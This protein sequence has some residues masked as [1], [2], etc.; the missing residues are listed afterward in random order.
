MDVQLAANYLCKRYIHERFCY[1]PDEWPPFQP[2]HFT[3]LVLI[4]HKENQTVNATQELV[5]TGN[6][7]S[8]LKCNLFSSQWYQSRS[9][10]ELFESFHTSRSFLIEGAPG[11]GKTVLLKEIA[12]QWATGKLPQLKELVFLIYLCDPNLKTMHSVEQLM[13]YIFKSNQIAVDISQYLFQTKGEYLTIIFDGYDEFPEE[14][15][16]NSL[17]ANIIN[18]SVLPECGL[19]ITSRPNASLHLRD[20]ADC[21]VEVLGFTE[22]DRLDYIQHALEGSDDKIRAVQLYLRSHY[23]I[24]ALCYIPLNMTILLSLFKN[25]NSS[26]GDEETCTLP[27]TQTEMYG[28]FITL[29][30]V[31]FLRKC[32]IQCSVPL[33][34]SSTLPSPYSKMFT[35][36]SQLAFTGLQNDKI[37]FDMDDIIAICPNL[38]MTPEN[39][40]GLG[41]LKAITFENKVSFHFLHFSIQEY[42]AANYIALLSNKKQIQLLKS[43]FWNISYFNTWIMY[44]GITGGKLLA[45]KHFL[46][47]NYF[48]LSSRLLK[49]SLSKHLQSDK[50]KSLHLFQCFL[51]AAGDNKLVENFS[52]D[53]MCVIDLSSQ[54]L[55]VTDVNTLAY[56]LLRSS[57]KH[58]KVLN[59]SKCHISDTGCDILFQKLKEDTLCIEKVDLSYNYLQE[60]SIL[61]SLH[62]FKTWHTSEAI[63]NETSG[64]SNHDDNVYS[65]NIY[66][67]AFSQF[68]DKSFSLVVSINYFLFAYKS[69]HKSLYNLLLNLPHIHSLYFDKCEWQLEHQT[70]EQLQN[71]SNLMQTRVIRELHMIDN[72]FPKHTFYNFFVKAIK[73]L[74][75]VFICERILP[76]YDIDYIGNTLEHSAITWILVGRSKIVGSIHTFTALKKMLSASE[77]LILLKSIRDICSNSNVPIAFHYGEIQQTFCGPLVI[78]LLHKVASKHMINICACHAENSCLIAN[79]ISYQDVFSALFI[80]KNLVSIFISNCNLNED[81]YEAA[82]D[83]F[84]K[85]TSLAILYLYDSFL[86]THFI[87]TI[88]DKLKW[89]SLQEF[90]VHSTDPLCT[91]NPDVLQISYSGTALMLVTRSMVTSI[92]PSERQILLSLQLEPNVAMWK[93]LK[94]QMSVV[95]LYQIIDVLTNTV[96]NVTSIDIS[97]CNLGECEYEAFISCVESRSCE[98]NWTKLNLCWNI[99]TGKLSHKVASLLSHITKL[100]ELN[101]SHNTLQTVSAIRIFRGMKNIHNLRKFNISYNW[102]GD[103]AAND[104]VAI[105]LSNT[106]L[107]ELDLSCN[108]FQYKSVARILS[109]NISNLI[110]INISH[111]NVTN[112]AAK[113]IAAF[114]TV[115][116]KLKKIKLNNIKLH[117]TGAIELFK[118]INI[119]ALTKLSFSHNNITQEAAD[120]LAYLLCLNTEIEEIDLSHNNLKAAGIIKIFNVLHDVTSLVKLNIGHNNISSSAAY[121]IGTVLLHNTKLQELDISCNDFQ[122]EGA[123]NIFKSMKNVINMSKLNIQSINVNHTAAY[124][125]ANFLFHNVNLKQLN[126]SYNDM[127]PVGMEEI[128]KAM[129]NS[130]KLEKIILSGN[131]LTVK[132]TRIIGAILS[133]N[134][135]LKE[136]K[137]S[138]SNL[139]MAGIVTICKHMNNISNLTQLDFSYVGITDESAESLASVLFQNIKLESLILHCS[140]MQAKDAVKVFKA[141]KFTSTLRKL[142]IAQNMVTDQAAYDLATVLSHNVQLEELNLSSNNLQANGA[143]KIF[144]SLKKSSNLLTF[145]ISNNSIGDLAA[146][147]LAKVLIQSTSL[148][149]LDL[150]YNDLQITGIKLV[151]QAMKCSITR[152]KTINLA[153]NYITDEAANDIKNVLSCNTMLRRFDISYNCLE[154]EGVTNIFQGIKNMKLK[155]LNISYTEI[156]EKAAY[157]IA[158]ALCHNTRL[159]ELHTRES[160]LQADST[161]KLFKGMDNTFLLI[162]LD[163]S[164]N[165]ITDKAADTI[166][167]VLSH[168]ANLEELDLSHNHFQTKGISQI[169]KKMNST[170]LTKLNFSH[171]MINNE[172]V[173]HI[174]HVILSNAKLEEVDLSYNNLQ[175]AVLQVSKELDLLN[176]CKYDVSHNSVTD[177]AGDDMIDM[178]F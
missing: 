174:M 123:I 162:K 122:S 38:T 133:C 85:Q 44:V 134:H 109:T 86:T 6:I 71:I 19:V 15:R 115:N 70:N 67:D 117:T 116:T 65:F 5:T 140:N 105:L 22:Q 26:T 144:K 138:N 149:K 121:H 51:E 24:N 132:I 74:N 57:N 21:R 3:S 18:R 127:K 113:N 82:V 147:D 130:L 40:N 1:M 27:S 29:T 77:S 167:S 49:T 156:S 56:Y 102:I 69:N 23:A 4:H 171:N 90:F 99:I 177:Q 159:K 154:S 53:E 119:S 139:E 81:Q 25:M 141:M 165:E 101:L 168:N 89:F 73:N 164:F 62:L 126:L 118:E 155:K 157:Y 35:E 33:F 160:N 88:C 72:G 39:W 107:E 13:Q 128:L 135:Q 2:K 120:S 145:N 43:T 54:T 55:S 59:L 96:S 66:L 28:K 146:E 114:L 97:G 76:D 9:I 79:K 143:I 124:A 178:Y 11:I 63:I 52:K 166:A 151:L 84:G 10:F 103:Q 163:I 80:H 8:S 68:I 91:L 45:W 95:V 129:A 125:I 12:Y 42:L 61:G 16:S 131:F 75:N 98:I 50:I 175:S 158:T 92:Q 14:E 37:V 30:I 110:K 176:L 111:N 173:D 20:M 60:K 93:F 64:H 152:L 48:L 112:I 32:G 34:N 94:K 169:C 106:K 78:P 83:A 46:S 41:L 31:R 17:F 153:N 170:R 100:E 150:S 136:M 36:L 47:G 137:L 161:I 87:K 58:W 7:A 104:L 108:D 142:N 172:A 148:T